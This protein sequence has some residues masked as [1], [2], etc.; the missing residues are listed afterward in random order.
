MRPHRY[1][2]IRCPHTTDFIAVV[3]GQAEARSRSGGTR[4]YV[5]FRTQ[6]DA[7][8]YA[9]WWNFEKPKR[10]AAWQAALAIQRAKRTERLAQ[11]G[12]TPLY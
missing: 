1:F 12:V 11:L 6:Q 4:S 7:E 2:A 3:K 8:E 9:A 10:E 5:S